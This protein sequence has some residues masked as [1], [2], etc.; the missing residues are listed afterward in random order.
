M[1]FFLKTMI[2]NIR[3]TKDK[4]LSAWY[5]YAENA[6]VA[7]AGIKKIILLIDKIKKNML[8]ANI[9]KAKFASTATLL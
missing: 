3:K 9:I 4:T 6:K 8:V 5:A 1:K 2:I 7:V